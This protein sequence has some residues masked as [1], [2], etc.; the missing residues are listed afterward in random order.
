MGRCNRTKQ[1][2]RAGAVTVTRDSDC[3]RTRVEQIRG[4]SGT[5][6]GRTATLAR[7]INSILARTF[8]TDNLHP[9]RCRAVDGTYQSDLTV[10]IKTSHKKVAEEK[11][12]SWFLSQPA[13]EISI[14]IR[15]INSFVGS[16]HRSLKVPQRPPCRHPGSKSKTTL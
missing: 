16:G 12:E 10:R 1:L 14:H 7:T 4:G 15:S 8:T 2:C 9:T 6:L 13:E 11:E 5:E 3:E